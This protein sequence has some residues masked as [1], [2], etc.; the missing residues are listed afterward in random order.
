MRV[1]REKFNARL[2]NEVTGRLEK[3]LKIKLSDYTELARGQITF[4]LT[5]PAE[6]GKN[7]G[8]LLMIDSKD[9]SDVLKTRLG[10][11]QKKWTEA[12]RQI[13][14]EKIRDVEFNSYQFTQASLQGFARGLMADG[15]AVVEDAE[16]A[17][18]KF[19]LFVGQSAS[20]LIVGTQIRDLEK[21]LARQAGGAVPSL[22]EVPS[23]QANHNQL[24]RDATGYAWL[25][26][27][28]IYEMMIK[29]PADDQR[30]APP[31]GIGNLRA[32]KVLPALGLG[33]LKSIAMK[34]AIQPEG[35]DSQLMLTVPEA[36][37]HGL[38]KIL[39]PPAKDASPPAFV[40]ADVAE[41]SRVRIDF[42][43]AWASFEGVLMKVDPSIAGLVQ[44]MLGAAGKDKDPDFDLKKSLVESVGDDFIRYVKA[45]KPF[46]RPSLNLIGARNPEQFLNGLKM[47]LRMLPE[48][49]GTSTLKEREFLGRKIFSLAMPQA[50][51]AQPATG[52]LHMTTSGG[53]VA[54]SSSSP[55][56]EEYL[57]SGDAPPKP[58]RDLPGFADVAQK[59]GGMNTGWLS[60][61]N[62][63]ESAR[64]MI[65]EQKTQKEP[66]PSSALSLNP[67]GDESKKL[68]EWIDFASLPPFDQISKYFFHSVMTVSSTPEGILY[69]MATPTPPGLK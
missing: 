59:A 8:F 19:L 21:V 65:E 28:P 27:K 14:T 41:F 26:V 16:A 18:N 54:I 53:Y 58:L 25:D 11:L 20:M 24:F 23:F 64:V 56:L 2:T 63:V 49:I 44:L 12:G 66:A 55:I 60:F 29:P 15:D 38:M 30:A 33:E 39:A 36:A 50:P 46:E 67:L 17:T 69:K 6:E 47:L 48:P 42:Q 13:K 34:V 37:R 52:E 57:R 3:D 43:Q 4:A 61:E 1:T 10:E 62:Q 35:F 45:T 51:G 22:A 68:Q 5:K 9:K 7:Q 40:P 32:Q 31:G